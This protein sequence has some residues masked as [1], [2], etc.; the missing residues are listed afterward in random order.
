VSIDALIRFYLKYNIFMS[1]L[2]Y[3]HEYPPF[4]GGIATS[5]EKIAKILSIK[6]Q[7]YVCCPT[8]GISNIKDLELKNLIIIRKNFLGGKNFK[9]IPLSQ[10]IQGLNFLKKTVKEINPE[11]IFYLG[12][13]AEIVGG[14][15]NN[16]KIKQIVRIAGSGIT[17]VLENNN[18]FSIV[19]KKY[20]YRVYKN[21][22]Q[23]I[24]VSKNTR[25]LMLKSNYFDNP[26]KIKLI[27]N[28]IDKEF[29]EKKVNQNI[30]HQ[31]GYS[32]KDFILITVSRIL[33]RKGQDNVI[34]ALSKI[35]NKDIKYICIGSGKYFDNF[36][37]LARKYN[38]E[39]RV[40]FLG[41]MDRAN[42]H[43]FYDCSDISILCNRTWNKK[44]E[45]LPNVGLEAMGRSKGLI[46]SKGTGTEEL[47]KDKVNGLIVNGENVDDI[48]DKILYAYNNKKLVKEM[49]TNA[50]KLVKENFSDEQMKKKYLDLFNES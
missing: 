1:I 34:K 44:I 6:H 14:L 48:K 19:K 32:D 38:L 29:I 16:K 2:I 15:L 31:L 10:Y 46:G 37:K 5:T 8:H 22:S 41:E 42:I 36:M 7:V 18:I 49:G 3:T 28:G 50:L 9:K 11:Y 33:P 35:P 24:A 21:S 30:R 45:G 27:Y 12:E 23:L 47:I 4:K 26:N 25:E 40:F 39:D 43:K 20:M 13:E 17:S